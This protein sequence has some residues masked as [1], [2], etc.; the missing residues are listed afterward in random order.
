MDEV[1][2]AAKDADALSLLEDDN[3]QRMA[4]L[5]AIGIELN[6]LQELTVTTLLDHILVIIG[7]GGDTGQAVLRRAQLAIAGQVSHILDDA[8]KQAE[9]LRRQQTAARL[10]L[11]PGGLGLSAVRKV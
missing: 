2:E 11:N 5:G 10:G 3:R 4:A 8:E 6:G 9:G 7:G 1:H